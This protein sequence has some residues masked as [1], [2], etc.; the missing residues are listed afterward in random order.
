MYKLYDPDPSKET[1]DPESPQ[2]P[3]HQTEP[4]KADLVQLLTENQAAQVGVPYSSSTSDYFPGILPPATR[5]RTI[6][7]YIRCTR[8]QPIFLGLGALEDLNRI[9]LI[10]SLDAIE[11]SPEDGDGVSRNFDNKERYARED[12]NVAEGPEVNGNT[13]GQ[14]DVG[15]PPKWIQLVR[16]LCVSKKVRLAV[17]MWMG[18]D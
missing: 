7:L 12:S 11:T 13:Q 18:R 15:P 14:G 16:G 10:T 1:K 3:I 2:Q 5:R 9:P 6:H 17:Y 4:K 8:S